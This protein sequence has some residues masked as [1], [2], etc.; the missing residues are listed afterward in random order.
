[1]APENK[2]NPTNPPA[3]TGAGAKEGE[4]GSVNTPLPPYVIP[5]NELRLKEWLQKAKPGERLDI[6]SLAPPPP[7]MEGAVRISEGTKFYNF[8]IRYN[9]EKKTLIVL[10][11]GF[12]FT[13]NP[14]RGLRIYDSNKKIIREVNECWSSITFSLADK[15]LAKYNYNIF[16]T[17]WFTVSVP[18]TDT[19]VRKFIALLASLIN[20]KEQE[21]KDPFFRACLNPKTPS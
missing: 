14:L 20:G 16:N 10:S 17:K 8:R 18:N 19:L 1:M 12:T 5:L 9:A 2:P 11:G 21:L 7:P 4:Q 6:S 3:P 13:V 15:L